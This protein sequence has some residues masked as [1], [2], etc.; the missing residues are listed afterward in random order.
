MTALDQKEHRGVQK[1]LRIAPSPAGPSQTPDKLETLVMQLGDRRRRWDEQDLGEEGPNGG[2]PRF[3][4][5]T[6]SLDRLI[7]E[8]RRTGDG[9]QPKCQDRGFLAPDPI[10][11]PWR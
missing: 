10:I 1:A 11:L 4:V 7:K 2:T 6:A 9:V 5:H 8:R 3:T